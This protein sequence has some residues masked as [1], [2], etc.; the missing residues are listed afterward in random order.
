MELS[1][2]MERREWNRLVGNT[3]SIDFL[4]AIKSVFKF[5]ELSKAKE[6]KMIEYVLIGTLSNFSIAILIGYYD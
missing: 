4:L 5:G 2:W 6:I 3:E 1:L